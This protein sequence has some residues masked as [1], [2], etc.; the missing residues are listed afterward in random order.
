MKERIVI[1]FI[2]VAL[3]LF[4]TT[5]GFLLY[6]QTK[7]LPKGTG[8]N[9]GV[10]KQQEEKSNLYLS[11]EKPENETLTDTRTVVITGKT[12]PENTITASTNQEDIVTTPSKDGSFSISI[13]IDTGVNKLITRAISP[14]GEVKIDTRVI[15]FSQEDF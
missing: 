13:A 6:Q 1:V 14:T 9:P 8:I 12:N 11:I 4:V 15:T 2:A 5:I 7:V 3:G 10:I